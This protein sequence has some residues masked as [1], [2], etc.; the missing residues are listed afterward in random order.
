MHHHPRAARATLLALAAAAVAACS[1]DRIA[2]PVVQGPS[3]A[4]DVAGSTIPF[5]HPNSEHYSDNGAKPATGRSGSAAIEA[6][7]LAAKDG[8]T[9]VEV[10]TGQLDAG[11]SGAGAFSK[12]QVKSLDDS[13]RVMHTENYSRLSSS[14]WSLNT[15]GLPDH[16]RLQLQANVGGIDPHR[17]DVVTVQTTVHKRPDL[18]VTGIS[19]PAQAFTNRQIAIEGMVAEGNGE[20]GA[21][22]DCL[23]YV[24][25]QLADQVLGMW[26]D[27]G[28]SVSCA[29]LTTIPTAGTHTLTVN[30]A[31]V[32]PGDW[33]TSNN[34]ATSTI[35]IVPPTYDMTWTLRAS[36]DGQRFSDSYTNTATNSCA[37]STDYQQCGSITQQVQQV[38]GQSA[39]QFD[40]STIS[41]DAAA[42]W[43]V[44]LTISVQTPSAT[45]ARMQGVQVLAPTSGMCSNVYDATDFT[46]AT[47]CADEPDGHYTTTDTWRMGTG[48]T[49]YSLDYGHESTWVMQ[50]TA[51]SCVLWWCNYQW[52]Q[53][54]YQAYSWSNNSGSPTAQPWMGGSFPITPE[55]SFG[56]TLVDAN[57]VKFLASGAATVTGTD[58]TVD[59][60][61][62]C[63]TM[64]NWFPYLHCESSST[65]T[66]KYS[67]TAS[68]TGNTN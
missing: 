63:T 65:E 11:T 34:S 51:T 16:S 25:G 37:G 40:V 32:V 48:Y 67:G 5:L 8:S 31:H 29:F 9:L 46:H 41:R 35:R 13:G 24:D 38:S 39:S 20:V 23:L 7:G 2:A 30:A 1:Q 3:A 17:T 60:P 10:T 47:I 59:Q 28:T 55:V 26:V 22:T 45:L 58:N 19:H 6:R 50:Y 49:Y 52:E 68:G 57:G 53:Q 43:P 64:T 36:A 18:I 12:M 62:A 21:T 15:M 61:Y 56:L 14:Y 54:N 42:V 4:R 27:A 66:W 33:D 44:T